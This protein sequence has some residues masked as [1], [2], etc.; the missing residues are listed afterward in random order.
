M[1]GHVK[2]RIWIL[3]LAASCIASA[4]AFAPPALAS[5][6]TT[7]QLPGPAAKVF[8]LDVSCPSQGLCVAVGTNNLTREQALAGGIS[9][10][11][12]GKLNA[13]EAQSLPQLGPDLVELVLRPYLGSEAAVRAA[14]A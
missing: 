4:L 11:I 3:M 6:W 2:P 10:L 1:K 9:R 12:V 13:G 8:M 7:A 14:R 5:S